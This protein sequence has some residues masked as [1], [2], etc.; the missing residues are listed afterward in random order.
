MFSNNVR[1]FVSLLLALAMT[2]SLFT[3][4]PLIAFAEGE[5][6]PTDLGGTEPTMYTVTWVSYDLDDDDGLVSYVVK[7]ESYAEGSD[8]TGE[9]PNVHQGL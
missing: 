9:Y 6:T 8:I 7:S 2:L 5:A 4:A 1:K 3:V